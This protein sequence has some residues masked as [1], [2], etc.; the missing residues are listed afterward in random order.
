M[1]LDQLLAP[2][3]RGD[4]AAVQLARERVA[5]CRRRLAECEE[6]LA[7]ALRERGSRPGDG[8]DQLE[9]FRTGVPTLWED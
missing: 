2:V 5:D 3:P 8:S 4:G 6:Q 9:L 7:A 1:S